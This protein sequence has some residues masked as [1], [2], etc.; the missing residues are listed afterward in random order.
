MRIHHANKNGGKNVNSNFI[1]SLNSLILRKEV[2]GAT[3]VFH[4][5]YGLPRC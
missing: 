1:L 2:C 5:N 4:V 3:R